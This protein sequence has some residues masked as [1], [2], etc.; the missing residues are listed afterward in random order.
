MFMNIIE[1]LLCNT[2]FLYLPVFHYF[3][4]WPQKNT[5]LNC[6]VLMVTNS[7]MYFF[8]KWQFS[9]IQV[10]T[11]SAQYIWKVKICVV[12]NWILLVV[13]HWPVTQ[14]SWASALK[15][16]FNKRKSEETIWANFVSSCWHFGGPSFSPSVRVAASLLT[17]LRTKAARTNHQICYYTSY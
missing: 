15:K 13:V 6:S 7:Q 4:A 1:D 17:S 10:N 14:G 11:G 2:H 5:F 8:V 16:G 3:V 9:E 12:A